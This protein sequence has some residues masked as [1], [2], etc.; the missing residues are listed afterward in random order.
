MRLHFEQLM[1]APQFKTI[2]KTVLWQVAWA[3]PRFSWGAE[4]HLPSQGRTQ[5]QS[6]K[7]QEEERFHLQE[8]RE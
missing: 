7:K 6:W 4:V 5:G 3:A 2:I 1:D 8:R